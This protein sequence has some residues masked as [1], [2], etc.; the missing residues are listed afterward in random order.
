MINTSSILRDG[1]ILA[2]GDDGEF[3]ELSLDKWEGIAIEVDRLMTK[4]QTKLIL[5]KL[6]HSGI[7]KLAYSCLDVVFLDKHPDLYLT[8][9]VKDY[10]VITAVRLV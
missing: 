8:S 10:D 6:L 7:M 3:E 1:T 5:K 2:L 4:K 9:F